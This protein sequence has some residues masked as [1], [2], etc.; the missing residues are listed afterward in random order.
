MP[1][2]DTWINQ[3]SNN[4]EETTIISNFEYCLGYIRDQYETIRLNADHP[5]SNERYEK[6]IEMIN[7]T[8]GKYKEAV[9]KENNNLQQQQQQ[10]EYE[11]EE[12]ELLIIINNIFNELEK[13]RKIA[14][15]KNGKD[16]LNDELE[17]YRLEEITL[18]YVLYII[19]EFAGKLI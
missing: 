1:N 4:N 19:L 6:I 12:K 18:D 11:E 9:N 10:N 15:N 2:L 3:N 13:K 16:P 7:Y 8:F 5:I 17:I 14:I